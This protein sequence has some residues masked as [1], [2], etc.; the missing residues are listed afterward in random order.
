MSFEVTKG[1]KF[2]I[3]VKKDNFQPS[4]IKVKLLTWTLDARLDFIQG[5]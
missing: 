5:Q 4:L 2:R 3:K 1:Q